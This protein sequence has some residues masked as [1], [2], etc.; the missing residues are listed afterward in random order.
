MGIERHIKGRGLRQLAATVSVD[1]DGRLTPLL[2]AQCRAEGIERV[3]LLQGIHFGSQPTML[4]TSRI[5]TLFERM[6]TLL[7]AR[8]LRTLQFTPHASLDG[9]KA[10]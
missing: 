6:N 7:I 9:G 8:C 1:R 3:A 2:S 4:L 10:G 5:E